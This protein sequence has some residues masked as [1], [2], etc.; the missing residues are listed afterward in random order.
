MSF[1]TFSSKENETIVSFESLEFI[2]P[3]NWHP[4]DYMVGTV[5]EESLEYFFKNLKPRCNI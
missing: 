4:G 1:L 2:L 5:L 3:R